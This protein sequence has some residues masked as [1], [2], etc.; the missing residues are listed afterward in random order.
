MAATLAAMRN[1]AR[2][3]R[4]RVEQR[5][6][7][8]PLVLVYEAGP[9]GASAAFTPCAAALSVPARAVVCRRARALASSVVMRRAALGARRSVPGCTP[10]LMS[11][12][13]V[14]LVRKGRDGVGA[15]AQGV[16]RRRSALVGPGAVVDVV[17][18]AGRERC[19]TACVE[20]QRGPR[21]AAAGVR[22]L[23]GRVRLRVGGRGRVGACR[24]RWAWCRGRAGGR[25]L[26][27]GAGGG[28]GA[29]AEWRAARSRGRSSP[30]FAWR[31]P[32]AVDRVR[33]V[34]MADPAPAGT[35]STRP[36]FARRPRK[37]LLAVLRGWWISRG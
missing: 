23:P 29:R 21:R 34:A 36:S 12:E 17:V 32:S 7:G 15:A 26:G 22:R 10:R 37:G 3:F 20:A 5:C 4:N 25:R 9:G 19:A 28:A 16:R 13:R 6:R 11:G 31:S 35:G 1:T 27:G 14:M 8:A 24:A 33:A 18:L 30:P 2:D